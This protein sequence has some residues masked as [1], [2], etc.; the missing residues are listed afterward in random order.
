LVIAGTPWGNNEA[1]TQLCS[2]VKEFLS[3]SA[4]DGD[5]T[6]PFAK[7]TH[8]SPSENHL[9]NA[10]FLANDTIYQKFNKENFD[11]SC[12]TSVLYFNHNEMTWAQLGQPHILLF[13][14]GKIHPLQITSD[15][16]LDYKVATPLPSR[17]IGL[18]KNWDLEVRSLKVNP[19]DGI[20]LL[21]R[22]TLPLNFFAKKFKPTSLEKFVQDLYDATVEENEKLP[23]WISLL[24]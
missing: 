10:L 21:A 23:F 18:E 2:T 16:S 13:R 8:L 12:E 3:T 5:V 20:I 14:D 4:F 24:A 17:L 6:S 22:P 15:L 9:R 1:L 7:L 11:T 19:T